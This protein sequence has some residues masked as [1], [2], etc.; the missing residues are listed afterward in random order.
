MAARIPVV[1]SQSVRREPA[2]VSC[3]E[4]LIT[5]L[6][7]TPGLDATL[8]GPLVNLQSGSTDHLCLEGL[9]GPFALIT[10]GSAS[11]SQ[12]QL[13]QLGIYGSIHDCDSQGLTEFAIDGS[14]SNDRRRIDHYQ[15]RSDTKPA[16]WIERLKRS[17]E[18]RDVRAFQIQLPSNS[19]GLSLAPTNPRDKVPYQLSARSLESKNKTASVPITNA[20]AIDLN[21]DDEA[22]E[23][24]DSLMDDLDRAD[25]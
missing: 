15:L 10:W 24:L 4:N 23:H 19:T 18:I 13:S 8:I 3:E 12:Q 9:K 21:S 22:W 11:E 7:F 1:V 14:P 16:Y 25:L 5:E 17:L 2:A 6:L 20:K